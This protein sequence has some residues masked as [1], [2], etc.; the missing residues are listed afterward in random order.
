MLTDLGTPNVAVEASAL[1]RT[2]VILRYTAASHVRLVLVNLGPQT[3]LAMND[4]LLGCGSG[5]RWQLAFC[6]ENPDYGGRGW[7]HP[8]VRGAGF[9]RRT[10]RGF[11]DWCR[12]GTQF[13]D[14]RDHAGA[15]LPA[16]GVI[17]R[18]WGEFLGVHLSRRISGLVP[19]R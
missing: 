16:R 9:S 6:S 5:Q 4:P 18:L 1:A 14:L 15:A 17:R 13:R 11:S 7:H 3:R 10:V 12:T 8:S 2:I 19:L